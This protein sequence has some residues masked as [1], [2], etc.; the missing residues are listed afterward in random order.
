MK[1]SLKIRRITGIAL[2]IAVEVALGFLGN[3]VSIG[4][5]NLNL[6]LIPIAVGACIFGPLCGLALGIING[7]IALIAPATMAFFVPHN[8]IATIVVCLAK[9]GLAGLVAGFI[10]RGLKSKS[11]LVAVILASIAIPVV[12][13]GLFI[14][15]VFAFFMPVYEG[16]AGEGANV[17]LFVITAT[18]TVNFLIELVINAGLATTVHRI[19]KVV[20]KRQ[21]NNHA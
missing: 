3:Y 13:T 9:T 17:Y 16:W 1:N 12:N 8:L 11:E 21:N 20:S 14:I 10:Y 4:Q 2:L 19:I 6:A 5:V 15:G 7:L 18:L